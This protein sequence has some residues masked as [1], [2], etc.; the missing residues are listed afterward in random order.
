M[1]HFLRL[2]LLHPFF[3]SHPS[4]KKLPCVLINELVRF[5]KIKYQYRLTDESGPSHKKNFTVLLKLGTENSCVYEEYIASG[6]SIKKAQHAAA[7]LALEETKLKHPVP[8]VKTVSNGILMPTVEL[9]TLAMKR[10]E[11]IQ[12]ELIHPYHDPKCQRKDMRR[13][14]KKVTKVGD[15]IPSSK[16]GPNDKGYVVNLKVGERLF[17]G[18]GVTLKAAKHDAAYAALLTLKHAPTSFSKVE[19]DPSSAPFI[20]GN[21]LNSCR[22][23]SEHKSPVSLVHENALKR[24]LSVTFQ[25]ER[26]SGPPHMKTFITRC[27]MG[28]FSTEGHGEAKRASKKRSAELMLEKLKTLPPLANCSVSKR[29]S[30]NSKS[31][32]KKILS[33]AKRRAKSL[34]KLQKSESD[35]SPSTVHPISRL[36]Q[37][38]HAKKEKEPIY[39][40]LEERGRKR[41]LEFIMQVSYLLCLCKCL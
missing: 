40:L 32:K 14:G 18:E 39:T 15:Q 3:K 19:L 22:T 5:N 38:Q 2:S 27:S 31:H 10:R 7:A 35:D 20:P 11:Q 30:N 1:I 26:E 17:K 12:Y 28:E 4:K 23:S 33:S 24:N 25:V 37:I 13:N 29:T 36:I 34:V 8:K 6:P 9:N 16:D 21:P 41:K